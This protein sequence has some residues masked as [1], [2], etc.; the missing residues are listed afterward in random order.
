VRQLV[1]TTLWFVERPPF[2][3]HAAA[4]AARKFRSTRDTPTERRA[5]T[6]WAEDRAVDVRSALTAV[7]IAATGNDVPRLPRA[8]RDEAQALADSA[9]V[10]MGGPGDIDLLYAAVLLSGAERVVE[11][12][13]AYGWS[14]LAILAAL[15]AAGKGSLASVDMPYPL[16]DNEAFVGVAVPQRFRARWTLVR[17]P[18]RF[19]LK[20]ALAG[21]GGRIDL[22][23]YDSDKSFGGRRYGYRLMWNALRPGGLFIS[24]DIQ[25]NLAFKEFVEEQGCVFAVT[26]YEGKYVGIARKA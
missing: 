15:E 4:L 1:R 22:C 14:S 10:A 11:T 5:A 16:L 21:F 17:R 6:A 20:S 7:G 24:D 26:R 18:D 9:S 3:P 2:W 13:V 8:L 12:G 23:H 19:G 25:D